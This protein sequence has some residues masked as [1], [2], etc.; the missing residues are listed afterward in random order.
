MSSILNIFDHIK[1]TLPSSSCIADELEHYISGSPGIPERVDTSKLI[2]LSDED[3]SAVSISS[4]VYQWIAAHEDG[5]Q[6]AVTAAA[7][8]IKFISFD[9]FLSS[10]IDSYDNALA[11]LQG[12]DGTEFSPREL[13]VVLVEGNKSNKWV[14]ELIA[15]N[16]ENGI[17]HDYIRLGEKDGREFKKFIEQVPTENKECIF[18]KLKNKTLFLFDDGSYSGTQIHDHVKGLLDTIREHNLEIKAIAI[19]IPYMTVHAKRRLENLAE[20]SGSVKV[21]IAKS[22]KIN[23]LNDIDDDAD[24]QHIATIWYEGDRSQLSKIGTIWLEHKLPND[25]SFPGPMIS[26]SIYGANGQPKKASVSI[27]PSITPPYKHIQ[28]PSNLDNIHKVSAKLLRG[29][30][31]N[32]SSYL[33]LKEDHKVEVVINLREKSET[34]ASFLLQNGIEYIHIPFDS[35]KI[36]DEIVLDFLEAILKNRSKCIYVHCMHGSDRTGALI[37]IAK[38]VFNN[39]FNEAVKAQKTEQEIQT[40]LAK[41]LKDVTTDMLDTKYGFHKTTHEHLLQYVKEVDV[42]SLVERLKTRKDTKQ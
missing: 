7:R 6:R 16:H 3:T 41:N 32:E 12:D 27:F 36:T 24:K 39:E 14:A 10:L 5:L 1:T 38:M 8:S 17:A 18:N 11:Q 9:T 15:T 21:I 30:Q 34:T 28:P 40:I 31:L 19:V 33:K 22:E 42:R 20:N 23:T 25:Q 26:G 13:G 29:G 2:S 4:T 35:K 37:A